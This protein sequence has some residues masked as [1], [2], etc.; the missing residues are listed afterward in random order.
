MVRCVLGGELS[1]S[2]ALRKGYG[3]LRGAADGRGAGGAACSASET[4][5]PPPME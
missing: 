3:T 2:A 1:S 4:M 5:K